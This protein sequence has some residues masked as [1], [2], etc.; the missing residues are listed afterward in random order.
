MRRRASV[1]IGAVLPFVSSMNSRLAWLQ[2]YASVMLSP[3]AASV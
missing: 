3:A 1:A 2:Q